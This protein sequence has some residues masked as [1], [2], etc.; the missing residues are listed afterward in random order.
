MIDFL[1][2]QANA[3]LTK[4]DLNRTIVIPVADVTAT[5]FDL[6]HETKLQLIQSGYDA[7]IAFLNKSPVEALEV[8][9]RAKQVLEAIPLKQ[10]TLDTSPL[11]D[12]SS[13]IRSLFE[14]FTSTQVNASA[15]FSN[16]TRRY[17]VITADFPL[18]YLADLLRSS[19]PAE[20]DQLL[21]RWFSTPIS[22]FFQAAPSK[23]FHSLPSAQ[24]CSSMSSVYDLLLSLCEGN[25]SFRPVL[26]EGPNGF[27]GLFGE[28]QLI[29]I[30][31]KSMSLMGWTLRVTPI[32][33]LCNLS[34]NIVSVCETQTLAEVI[35]TLAPHN[36]SSVPIVSASNTI[37][38]TFSCSDLRFFKESRRV[39]LDKPI[40]EY[41][42]DIS[43]SEISQ[44]LQARIPITASSHDSFETVIYK[45][46]ATGVRRVWVVDMFDRL[47]GVLT[48]SDILKYLK[49]PFPDLSST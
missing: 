36:F 10:C 37:V 15:V 8:K 11:I 45:M 29:S 43:Q 38:A 25:G 47:L 1:V 12:E 2:T 42:N 7:T 18:A 33:A 21:Q 46:S 48:F 13:T 30:L 4:L 31:S 9:N 14:Y 16:A 27:L 20:I 49:N 28:K 39:M 22:F 19:Q 44:L 35:Q 17:H 6:S 41:F 24:T 40:M 26:Q 5:Q 3:N 32:A 34:T 23:P